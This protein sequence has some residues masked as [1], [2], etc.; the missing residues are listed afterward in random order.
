MNKIG[1]CTDTVNPLTGCTQGCEYCYA[2][3][4]A[5]RL[6][7]RYGYPK[8]DPFKPTFHFDKLAAIY[9]L[10]GKGKRVFLSSMGDWF[11]PGVNR[12]QVWAIIDAVRHKP[13]HT[14]LVLTKRPDRMSEILGEMIGPMPRNMWFG[15]S[16]TCQE[17]AWRIRSLDSGAWTDR[18]FVSFEPLLEDLE[19]ID[20]SGIQ[21]AIVGA[22]SGNRKDKIIPKSSWVNRLAA[23]AAAQGIPFFIKD[24]AL[25]LCL[26][27]WPP[28]NRELL[29]QIPEA[30]L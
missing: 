10:K 5:Y 30:M 14:F 23:M 6:K 17:D 11:S 2:R 3:K 7:G 27:H 19:G 15:V 12:E 13:D 28:K 4:M 26:D 22:E 9:G 24:N 18:L 21:W 1:W 25:K 29:Q 20:L 8:D 16:V